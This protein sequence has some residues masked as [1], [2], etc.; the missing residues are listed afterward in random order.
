LIY[1]NKGG[2]VMAITKKER[3]ELHLLEKR[4]EEVDRLTGGEFLAGLGIFTSPLNENEKQRLKELRDKK[5]KSREL[6]GV[7]EEQQSWK[8][9][10]AFAKKLANELRAIHSSNWDLKRKDQR[11]IMDLLIFLL[12]KFFNV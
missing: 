1:K 9:S 7:S 11:L 10:Y 2:I 5:R 3:R 4:Q 8:R 12:E 6:R